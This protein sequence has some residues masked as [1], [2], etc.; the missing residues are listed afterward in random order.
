[1][2]ASCE[3][4]T[5]IG[6]LRLSGDEEGLREI[7]FQRRARPA[8]SPDDGRSSR[9]PFLDVISELEE[10]F[11]GRLTRFRVRLAPRGTPFQLRVWSLLRTIPYGETTTYGEIARELGQPNACRAV[12]AA[13]GRNPIPVI[14]PCHRVI[15]SDG[16]LT[17]FGGGLDIKRALLDLE[18]RGCGRP[19]TSDSPLLPFGEENFTGVR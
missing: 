1:M 5:P 18:A 4:P 19:A 14:V 10:Y 3:I 2:M 13:N 9:E 12:G 15:G 17:G 8:V 7:S 6:P 16:S 11:A